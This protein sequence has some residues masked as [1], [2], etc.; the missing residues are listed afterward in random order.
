MIFALKSIIMFSVPQT[1]LRLIPSD[2]L[3][4]DKGRVELEIGGKWGTICH[5]DTTKETVLVLC[6]GLGYSK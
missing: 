2:K 3:V 6:K 5:F 4:P 1:P